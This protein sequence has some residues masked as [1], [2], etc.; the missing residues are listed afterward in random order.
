MT[1]TSSGV[2]IVNYSLAKNLKV[3][4]VNWL[5][6]GH[7]ARVKVKNLNPSLTLKTMLFLVRWCCIRKIDAQEWRSWWEVGLSTDPYAWPW[8]EHSLAQ[9]PGCNP[10]A[11]WVQQRAMSICGGAGS[12]DQHH[13]VGRQGTLPLKDSA[14]SWA[15]KGVKGK[16]TAVMRTKAV[17]VADSRLCDDNKIIVVC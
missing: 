10:S 4:K 9:G 2:N 16:L 5:A 15:Q 6:W 8:G 3:R 1:P 14:E 17:P 11:C 13:N 12:A 7:T